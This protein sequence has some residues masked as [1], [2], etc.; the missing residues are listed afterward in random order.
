[1]SC[2]SFLYAFSVYN[3]KHFPGLVL[4]A[5]PALCCADALL[6]GDTSRDSTLILGLYTFCFA[7]PGSITK[8]TPSMVRDVSAIFVDTTTLR[9]I[10]PFGLFGGGSSKMRCC[11]LGGSVEYSGMHFSSP[12]SGPKLSISLFILLQATSISS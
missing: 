5:R 12:T 9:P 7:N 3:R 10:A 4:P 8:T 1:M 2:I 6:I 11:R